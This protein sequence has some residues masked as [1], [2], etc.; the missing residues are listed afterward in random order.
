MPTPI[1]TVTIGN[2]RFEVLLF[3][4]Q[5]DR[6]E[7]YDCETA[8][9][10]GFMVTASSDVYYKG[11]CLGRVYRKDE[12]MMF[13][14]RGQEVSTGISARD[15]ECYIKA[16]IEVFKFLVTAGTIT[17]GVSGGE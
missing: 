8:E 7:I 10:T 5:D 4:R 12:T 3:T 16:E 15:I 6:L 11:E 9:P 17:L 1:N 2:R 13:C 14:H